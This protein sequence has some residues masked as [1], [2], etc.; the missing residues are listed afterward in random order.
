MHVLR[1][2]PAVLLL[3]VGGVQAQVDTLR[4]PFTAL[5][6]DDGLSQGMVTSIAQDKYGFMWFATKDG[7]D[8]YDGYTFTTFR[9]D[10]Q[11]STTIAENA[12]NWIHVDRAQRMWVV[13]NGGVDLFD[14]ATE[15]FAH[16]PI[17][18]PDF[19]LREM[20]Q[21][22]VDANGD[23]WVCGKGLL[24]KVTFAHPVEPGKPLPPC[25]LKWF[26]GNI[27]VTLLR[28]DRL[29][30]TIDGKMLLITPKHDGGDNMDTVPPPGTR[31]LRAT[32]PICTSWRTLRGGLSMAWAR[33][34]WCPSFGDHPVLCRPKC[35]RCR[36]EHSVR[37]GSPWMVPARS[38]PTA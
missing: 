33:T 27:G 9:H 28:D 34:S 16:V 30:G 2:L 18:D 17:Q 7:L 35:T 26:E 14:P 1:I 38:G 4:L 21:A 36:S 13:T 32:H 22:T 31:S 29:W 12:V 15:R 3:N 20:R 6:I 19:S 23:L 25:T 11:D 24:V 37:T 10:P 5:G 8:R